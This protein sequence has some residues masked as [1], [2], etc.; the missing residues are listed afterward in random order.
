LQVL[1]VVALWGQV[2]EGTRGWRASHGY[3]RFVITGPTIV[4]EQRAAVARRYGVP[5]HGSDV[6]ARDLAVQLGTDPA[7]AASLCHGSETEVAAL[8]AAWMPLW[9]RRSQA[10]RA[11]LEASRRRPTVLGMWRR[12]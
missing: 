5:V 6:P 10:R 9:T 3:P 4:P 2:V 7:L 12:R 11:E 8:L 1:G